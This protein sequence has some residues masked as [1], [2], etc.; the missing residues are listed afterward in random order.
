MHYWLKRAFSEFD[1]VIMPSSGLNCAHSQLMISV[2]SEIW[3]QDKLKCFGTRESPSGTLCESCIGYRQLNKGVN[4]EGFGRRHPDLIKPR[5][6]P[7]E[8]ILCG[9]TRCAPDWERTYSLQLFFV[10]LVTLYVPQ[11]WSDLKLNIFIILPNFF[12]LKEVAV[13]CLQQTAL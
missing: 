13:G 3:F 5:P 1:M 12:T 9:A 2:V 10:Q 6:E 4:T 8:L 11:F 7:C